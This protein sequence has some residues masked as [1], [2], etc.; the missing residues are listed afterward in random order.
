[1]SP[2]E[3]TPGLSS[4]SAQGQSGFPLHKAELSITN[5]LSQ[6]HWPLLPIL[7]TEAI[8]FHEME[9]LLVMGEAS[10][11]TIPRMANV[12]FIIILGL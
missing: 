11:S 6:K 9:K 8:E 7:L 2:P 4:L 5:H 1:M 12:T 3:A 10:F